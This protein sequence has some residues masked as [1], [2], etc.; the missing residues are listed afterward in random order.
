MPIFATHGPPHPP[1]L[2]LVGIGNSAFL[3]FPDSWYKPEFSISVR[4]PP[5][6]SGSAE[7]CFVCRP[8]TV[9]SELAIMD[10]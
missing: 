7:R 10:K 1:I 8:R 9:R 2:N 6:L 5:P 3:G 4:Y